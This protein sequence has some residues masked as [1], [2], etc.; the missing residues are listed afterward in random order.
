[1]SVFDSYVVSTYILLKR[2]SAARLR[3]RFLAMIAAL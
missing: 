1:M 2:L 3:P